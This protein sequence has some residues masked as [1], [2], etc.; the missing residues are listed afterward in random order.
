MSILDT[1]QNHKRTKWTPSIIR[2]NRLSRTACK[3][4]SIKTAIRS[5]TETVDSCCNFLTMTAAQ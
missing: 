4:N 1:R 3:T 5:T 2:Q